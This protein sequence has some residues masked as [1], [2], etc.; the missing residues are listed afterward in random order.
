MLYLKREDID[1]ADVIDLATYIRAEQI[2]LFS[3]SNEAI[4][5]GRIDFDDPPFWNVGSKSGTSSRLLSPWEEVIENTG[6]T[7][8][9]NTE[10]NETT[11]EKP[12]TIQQKEEQVLQGK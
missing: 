9:W 12:N 10:T 4:L 1:P 8:Y 6:K 11:W 2:S 5:D 7:Y 3:I